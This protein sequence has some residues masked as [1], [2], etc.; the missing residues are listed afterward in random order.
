MSR[1]SVMTI[2]T[3]AIGT[4]EDVTGAADVVAKEAALKEALEKE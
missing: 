1:G 3:A 4:V 2:E